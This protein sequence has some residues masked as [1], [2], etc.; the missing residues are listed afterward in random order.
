LP[1]CQRPSANGFANSGFVIGRDRAR[2][3]V[4]SRG[5]LIA[6]HVRV[7]PQRDRWIDVARASRH[8]MHE[9]P[10]SSRVVA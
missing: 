3:D 10:A 1:A 2:E 9:Q 7:D 6:D 5:N 4:R 8:D